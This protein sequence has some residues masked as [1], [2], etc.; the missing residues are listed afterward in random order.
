MGVTED[1]EQAKIT[2]CAIRQS[3]RRDWGGE[4]PVVQK[5]LNC[6]PVHSS[7]EV[8]DRIIRSSQFF[9]E[10]ATQVRSMLQFVENE[11]EV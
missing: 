3:G 8:L 11:G 10:V 6:A 5:E 1:G 9:D 7:R 4:S 2:N